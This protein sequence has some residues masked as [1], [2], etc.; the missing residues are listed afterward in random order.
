MTPRDEITRRL[1]T[2]WLAKADADLRLAEH[3]LPDAESFAGAMA[4]HCQQAVEKYVKALLTQRQT[5]FPKTHDIARLLDL[6]EPTDES[7]AEVLRQTI[8]LTP[9]GVELWYP[10]EQ[11]DASTEFARVAV[12]LARS[13]REGV[14]AAL[15]TAG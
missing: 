7:L 6:L 15:Q 9:F 1:V 14:V 11:P 10:G 8:V 5:S 4:F 3:L 12:D 13:A 2:E